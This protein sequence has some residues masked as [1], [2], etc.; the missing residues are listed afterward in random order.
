MTTAQFLQLFGPYAARL[1]EDIL[2]RFGPADIDAASRQINE[3]GAFL[4][5]NLEEQ[6]Q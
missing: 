3:T 4:P 6:P 5:L 2:P 1:D